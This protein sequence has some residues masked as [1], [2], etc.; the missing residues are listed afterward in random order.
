MN[1]LLLFVVSMI[2]LATFVSASEP[3]PLMQGGDREVS[4]KL[5]DKNGKTPRLF[6]FN[7]AEQEGTADSINYW[8]DTQD[9]KEDGVVV[10]FRGIRFL[11]SKE[12]PNDLVVRLVGIKNEIELGDTISL[13]ELQSGKP[14]KLHFGP[15]ALGFGPISGT[16]DADMTLSYDPKSR[17][18]DIAEVSGQLEWKRPFHDAQKD[19]GSLKEVTGEI[20]DVAAGGIV[21]QPDAK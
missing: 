5:K 3:R 11:R 1:P 12:R 18:L 21:L 10:D 20:G 13:A 9:V 2:S 14:Q 19:G 8:R 7:S 17:T 15:A 16:T 4:F 6:L